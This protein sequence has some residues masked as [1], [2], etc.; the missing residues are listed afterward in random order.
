VERVKFW[1][2]VMVP[3]SYQVTLVKDKVE[4]ELKTP[5]LVKVT[6]V[7]DKVEVELKTPLLVKEASVVQFGIPTITVVVAPEEIMYFALFLIVR[8][9]TVQS[10]PGG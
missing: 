6:L 2:P 10:V 8:L 7:K 3:F 5:L 1:R 9:S 4:V